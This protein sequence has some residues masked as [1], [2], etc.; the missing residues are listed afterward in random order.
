MGL[1]HH[2]VVGAEPTFFNDQ[3]CKPLGQRRK[4][5]PHSSRPAIRLS[6]DR[7]SATEDFYRWN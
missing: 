3:R 2:K 7:H 1:G 4:W 5:L 6:C